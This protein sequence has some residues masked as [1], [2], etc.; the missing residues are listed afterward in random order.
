MLQALETETNVAT[1]SGNENGSNTGD[2]KVLA[3]TGN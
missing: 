2:S 3:F 1:L